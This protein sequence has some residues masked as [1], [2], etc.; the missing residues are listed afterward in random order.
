MSSEE[1][2]VLTATEMGMKNH[3][4]VPTA[5]IESISGLK[6]GGTFKVPTTA[7]TVFSS[8][9]AHRRHQLCSTVCARALPAQLIKLLAK[10][11][12]VKHQSKPYDGYRLTAKGYDYLA[13]KSLAKRG[14]LQSLGIQVPRTPV[15]PRP[16]LECT[17]SVRDRWVAV[18]EASRELKR[19]CP[20]RTDRGGQGVRHLHRRQHRGKRG[21]AL[22]PI[23]WWQRDALSS[24][25]QPAAAR[26]LCGSR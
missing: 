1:F 15:C 2:R 24:P 17:P 4:L 18:A 21:A 16:L 10:N 3:E 25:G 9:L 8:M 19:E 14:T 11:K 7:P 22:P 6:R 23:N 5:L 12:L 13:L 26:K 20:C